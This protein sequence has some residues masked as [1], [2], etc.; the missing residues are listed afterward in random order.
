MSSTRDNQRRTRITA[1]DATDGSE[2]AHRTFRGYAEVVDADGGTVLVTS[3][4]RKRTVA[5]DP[6]TGARERSPK[7]RLPGRPLG[8]PTRRLHR[9]SLPR[10]LQRGVDR[11]GP[12]HQAVA[13][14]PATGRR[15]LARRARVASTDILA[16]GVGPGE[17]QLRETDGPLLMKY[18][19]NWFGEVQWEDDD[20]LLLDANG[21]AGAPR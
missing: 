2:V 4:Q 10:G 19:A 1:Y 17:V 9:R 6:A 20:T 7:G 14:V 8:G 15:L 3:W 18:H 21:R 16:D 5:W 11:L 12:R 13:F